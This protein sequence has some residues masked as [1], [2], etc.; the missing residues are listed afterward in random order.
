MDQHP[1][2][3]PE[4]QP[5][6]QEESIFNE[7]ELV[8]DRYMKK[9]RQA[10]NAI[11]VVAAIQFVFG[12]YS[13]LTA[14]EELMYIT[15]GIMMVVALMFL[16][17]AIWANWKP[18]PAILIALI[19]YCGLIL[20]DLVYDPATIFRGI[21]MKVIIIIYLVKGLNNAAEARRMKQALGVGQGIN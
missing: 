15:L 2:Q 1:E 10:R 9:V 4:Q 21:I 11:Y 6:P 12:L 3:H 20:L 8:D 19:L 18:Y 16:G 5:A 14:P 7:H 13:G 17:L